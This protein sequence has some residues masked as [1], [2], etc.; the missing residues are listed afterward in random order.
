[1]ADDGANVFKEP[2]V[3]LVTVISTVFGIFL[4]YIVSQWLENPDREFEEIRSEI[5]ELRDLT[6]T[7]RDQRLE[8][9]KYVHE[10]LAP[11]ITKNSGALG[12]IDERISRIRSEIEAI[13]AGQAVNSGNFRQAIDTV[14]TRVT[15]TEGDLIRLEALISSIVDSLQ[16]NGQRV[17][18][19]YR[20]QGLA[21]DSY[22][23]E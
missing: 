1:M 14:A 2:K 21:V 18:L 10:N 11:V 6:L 17:P 15:K 23:G 19:P 8:L 4:T 3:V 9:T 12:L 16:R 22:V 5:L 20:P 13:N 7:N